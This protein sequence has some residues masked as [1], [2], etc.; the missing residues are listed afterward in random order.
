MLE[1]CWRACHTRSESSPA[2]LY[3]LPGLRLENVTRNDCGHVRVLSCVVGPMND[4]FI[5]LRTQ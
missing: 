5:L 3:R 1:Q 4:R 2:R